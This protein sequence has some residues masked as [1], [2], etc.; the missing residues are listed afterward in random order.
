[1]LK[2]SCSIHIIISAFCDLFNILEFHQHCSPSTISHRDS[3]VTLFYSHSDNH[4]TLCFPPNNWLL[5]KCQILLGKGDVIVEQDLFM[6]QINIFVYLSCCNK[7]PDL[8]GFLVF[9]FFFMIEFLCVT[10]LAVQELVL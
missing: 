10:V 7:I 3:I 2:L 5:T 9:F 6:F 1:M 4:Y 8:V